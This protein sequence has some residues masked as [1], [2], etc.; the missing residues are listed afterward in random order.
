LCFVDCKNNLNLV[1]LYINK[2]TGK[3]NGFYIKGVITRYGQ[4]KILLYSE[5]NKHSADLKIDVYW[6]ITTINRFIDQFRGKWK[7]MRE[8]C[9]GTVTGIFLFV[10]RKIGIQY[11]QQRNK[12]ALIKIL[13]LK[14]NRKVNLKV[15]IPKIK[16][17]GI[18]AKD[19]VKI[20]KLINDNIIQQ[21]DIIEITGIRKYKVMELMKINHNDKSYN[22]IANYW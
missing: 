9:F 17:I 8:N 14:S 10:F 20:D 12:C 11:N 16:E 13:N 15:S 7:E 4:Q 21:G 3:T 2:I 1:S 6:S 22:I 5:Q 19:C 18:T